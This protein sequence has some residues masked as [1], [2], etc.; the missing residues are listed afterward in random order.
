MS[1]DSKD[2]EMY[3]IKPNGAAGREHGVTWD[4][5]DEEAAPRPRPTSWVDGFRR[6]ET[7][8]VISHKTPYI[9]T[10][11]PDMHAGMGS[12]HYDLGAANIKTASTALAR[13]LKGRHLQMIAF[14]GSIG[15]GV[16]VASG[17]SLAIG[18][19]ASLFLAFFLHGIFQYN[20]WI[21]LGALLWDGR[22]Y[23]I[24][25][26]DGYLSKAIFVAVFL[27][28]IMII[29]LFGVK[30]YGEAEFVF[31]IIKIMGVVGFILLG[32]AIN[33]GG[34]P[35]SGY[36]GWQYWHDPGAFNNGFKGFCTVM[37]NSSGAFAGTELIGLAAAEAANPRK[38]LPSAIKQVFW[39]ISIFYCTALLLIGLLVPYTDPRLLG[40]TSSSDALASPFVIAIES[41]GI[42]IVP[43]IMNVIILIAVVSVGNSAVYGSSRTLLALAEQSHAPRIFA[44][45]DRQGRPVVAILLAC[46]IGLL[47]FLAD[48]EENAIIFSWL[49]S[50]SGLCMLFT[51]GSICLCHIRFRKAWAYSGHSLEQL[52]FRS[53]VGVNGS[54]F[55]FAGFAMIL[56]A[57]VWIG[58]WPLSVPNTPGARCQA[59]FL[60]A[61]ALPIVLGSYMVHK[62][63]FRTQLV[64]TAKMDI[65][66][67]RRYFRSHIT[68]E[69]EREEQ[70]SWPLWKKVYNF[71]C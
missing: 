33:V 43:S 58:I 35:D 9:Q 46:L 18:G 71:L 68:N 66:T 65:N 1:C 52:P 32:A 28:L 39:R 11:P 7:L 31:S 53:S 20:F 4:V 29:N 55:A 63:W 64:R 27:A 40:S 2:A 30:A 13:E 34:H 48:V 38:S 51:W 3:E 57:Q 12:H 6:A 37:V 26:W 42:T 10:A 25:Y 50:T 69:Q 15:T 62:L 21:P 67:G 49:L 16:F 59:F 17:G 14:G 41:A 45:V 70:L 47:A 23:T 54:W 56:V 36:I 44:Y 8:H 61:M 60:R 24:N 22:A 19:P 5:S